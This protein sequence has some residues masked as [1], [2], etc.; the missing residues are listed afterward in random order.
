MFGWL[1]GVLGVMRGRSDFC[2]LIKAGFIYVSAVLDFLSCLVGLQ[3]FELTQMLWLR[4]F[5]WDCFVCCV[6]LI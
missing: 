2:S 3:G 6:V 5:V 1:F 4:V